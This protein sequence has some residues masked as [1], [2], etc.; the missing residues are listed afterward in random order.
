M[1]LRKVNIRSSS[2]TDNAASFVNQTAKRLHVRKITMSQGANAA[3]VI[4]D[5]SLASLDEIP[6]SQFRAND[7]RSHIMGLQWAHEGGTASVAGQSQQLVLSFNRDD[8]FLDPDEA[9]FLN[10]TDVIGNPPVNTSVNIW[11]QD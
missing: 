1:P 7:S 5:I 11:Y 4:G 9:L 8:L 10:T 2:L 6:V 3:T